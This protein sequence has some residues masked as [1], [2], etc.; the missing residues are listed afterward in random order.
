MAAARE[1]FPANVSARDGLRRRLSRRLSRYRS[2]CTDAWKRSMAPPLCLVPRGLRASQPKIRLCDVESVVGLLQHPQSILRLEPS[3]IA[4]EQ[5]TSGLAFA[6]THAPAQLVQR[7]HAVPVRVLDDDDARVGDVDANLH[8]GRR[9]QH[10]RLALA[11]RAEACLFLLAAHFPV[12]HP[13]AHLRVL[14]LQRDELL[15]DGFVPLETLRRAGVDERRD[16]VALSP[17][18]TSRSIVSY[19]SSCADSTSSLV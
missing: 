11:E 3:L 9:H 12:E 17:V 14:L 2:V 15:L 5:E 19:A 18:C 4:D 10:L 1:I 6:T 8:H 7:G 13:E 16:D